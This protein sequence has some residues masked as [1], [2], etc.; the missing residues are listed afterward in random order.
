ML[1]RAT[2]WR[3][4]ATVV[5]GGSLAPMVVVERFVV[6]REARRFSL[7]RASPQSV[8]DSRGASPALIIAL[9]TVGG[10]LIDVGHT[11]HHGI[12]LTHPCSLF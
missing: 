9:R 7:G 11:R 3:G 4:V 10:Q 5:N 8:T 12:Y 2:A 6:G 1:L